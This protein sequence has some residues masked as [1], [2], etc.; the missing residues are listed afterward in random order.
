MYVDLQVGHSIF[1]EDIIFHHPLR[2]FL[3]S[4]AILFFPMVCSML[5][6]AA[7]YL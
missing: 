3:P 4:G 5:N 2:D 1:K 6:V 7:A